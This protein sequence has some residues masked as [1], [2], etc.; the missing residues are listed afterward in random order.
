[1]KLKP[2][3]WKIRKIPHLCC[4]LI[5]DNLQREQSGFRN[6]KLCRPSLFERSLR[7]N[8]DNDSANVGLGACYPLAIFPMP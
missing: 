1:M 2:P 5:L 6:G 4:P 7:I 3:D 8:P